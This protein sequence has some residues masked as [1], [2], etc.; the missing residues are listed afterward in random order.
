[1]AQSPGIRKAAAGRLD[2]GRYTRLGVGSLFKDAEMTPVK[3][4]LT[5]LLP[6]PEIDYITIQGGFHVSAARRDS[7]RGTRERGV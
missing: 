7:A 3:G 1:M 2:H 6:Q 4:Q 5:F